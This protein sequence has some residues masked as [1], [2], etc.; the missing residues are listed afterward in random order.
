[1]MTHRGPASP[2]KRKF[3]ELYDHLMKPMIAK[4]KHLE[5]KPMQ[6]EAVL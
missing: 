5:L 3:D 4:S 1:M 2:E 6:D